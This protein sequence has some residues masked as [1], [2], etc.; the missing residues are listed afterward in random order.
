MTIGAT[1]YAKSSGGG[2]CG[3]LNDGQLHFAELGAATTAGQSTGRGWI[4][5]ALGRP[6]ELPCGF[7]LYVKYNGRVTYAT[8]ADVGYG[9]G[10]NGITSDPHFAMDL[11]Y[12]LAEWLH[13][14]GKGDIQISVPVPASL[15]HP[16]KLYYNP[17]MYANVTPERIDQGVD[18]SINGGY[19]IA[20]A[21]G[22][23]GLSVPGGIGW[24]GGYVVYTITQPGP[25]KGVNVYYAEGVTPVVRE[26]ERIRAGSRIANLRPHW[27]SGLEIGYAND[28]H[29]G[30]SWAYDHGGYGQ[31]DGYSNAATRSG[32][33]FSQLVAALG[34]PAGIVQGAVIGQTPPWHSGA[35]S[36]AKSNAGTGASPIPSNILALPSANRIVA[37]D[38]F[39]GK[40]RAVWQ[41]L[42]NAGAFAVAQSKR[43]RAYLSTIQYVSDK[44]VHK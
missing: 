13:F 34:G 31:S 1:W 24:S 8:K 17:L 28:P 11:Y 26:G 39:S 41:D 19:L 32:I 20:I 21:D 37:Y 18:Y 42:G 38:D 36:A 29:T 7:G 6:G 16:A 3:N 40:V 10:G 9:Q 5:R 22:V 15:A 4:A 14:D 30:R 27:H 44:G 12:N 25:L 23:V 35:I 2:S 33:A 43:T